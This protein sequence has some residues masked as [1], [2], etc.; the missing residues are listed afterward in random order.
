MKSR[1]EATGQQS[2]K[3][4]GDETL[5]PAVVDSRVPR[6]GGH[7]GFVASIHRQRSGRDRDRL[8]GQGFVPEEDAAFRKTVADYEKASGNKI[9]FSI[10]PFMALNQKA[11]SATDQRRRSRPDLPRRAGDD[12]A[13]ERL[14]TTSWRTSATSW[15]RRSPSSAR[16]RC[17]APAS[18]TASRSDAASTFARSSRRATPFHIWGDL[19]TKAGFKLSDAPEHL[20]RLLGFL[21]AG[22][23]GIAREG[24]AQAVRHG[25]A[26]H[27]RRTE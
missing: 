4:C 9:D 6:I 19:V 11:I 26:D 7:G 3:E 10:M 14:G 17:C 21:Q 15:R 27:H 25:P 5:W 8:A 1:R 20:G 13:A 2:G 18:T 24:H 23:E 16:P 22:T 12:S